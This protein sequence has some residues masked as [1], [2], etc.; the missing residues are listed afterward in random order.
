[1]DDLL[2]TP[3]DRYLVV[4]GRL[5]RTANRRLD[6]SERKRLV[7][8]LMDARRAVRKALAGGL[9]EE[10]ARARGKVQF[11][12]EQL[13]ERGAVWWTHGAPDFNRHLIK[14]TPYSDWWEQR[15]G[16]L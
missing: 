1:M 7:G 12:K 6:P 4:R 11:A 15:E 13:G 10:L 5:W 2:F 9:V 8:E 3:D 16:T 14:N